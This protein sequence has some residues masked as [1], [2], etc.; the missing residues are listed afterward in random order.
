MLTIKMASA[1]TNPKSPTPPAAGGAGVC[2]T[3]EEATNC[4]SFVSNIKAIID[5]KVS[6]ANAQ[7]AVVLAGLNALPLIIRENVL[8]TS[9]FVGANLEAITNTLA[10]AVDLKQPPLTKDNMQIITYLK[11][12][13]PGVFQKL[14]EHGEKTKDMPAEERANVIITFTDDTIKPMFRLKSNQP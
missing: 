4:P 10:D 8:H 6:S 1:K 13:H 5:E 11:S 12:Q 7:I 2:S 9:R 14:L 3:L